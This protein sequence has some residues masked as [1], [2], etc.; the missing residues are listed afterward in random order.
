[1]KIIVATDKYKGTFSSREATHEIAETLRT[2]LAYLEKD[3]EI[4]EKPLA[5]GG[6][7]TAETLGELMG[8]F[9]G[10]LRGMTSRPVVFYVVDDKK[11]VVIDCSSVLSLTM[12][13]E[14]ERGRILEASSFNAGVLIRVIDE[15]IHPERIYLG[16]GG[17]STADGGAGMLQALGARFYTFDRR[18]IDRPVSPRDK[19]VDV[20]FS[21]IKPMNITALCDVDVPLLPR[22]GVAG[23]SLD[24]AWQKGMTDEN[25]PEIERFLRSL[26]FFYPPRENS[27]SEGAGGGIGM[28]L[29]R[30]MGAEMVDGAQFILERS[31]I[32]EEEPDLIITGEGRLDGQSAMGKLPYRLATEG[33]RL[34]IPVVAIA[35]EITSD[36]D[37]APYAAAYSASD[38]LPELDDSKENRLLRLK[39]AAFL[40]TPEIRE[41][42]NRDGAR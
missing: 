9:R 30:V 7:G 6:E 26:D 17:T 13:P 1:M 35:G 33:R 3:C 31:G 5:D 42:L 34:G 14:E 4:V 39:Q 18:L 11:G 22:E 28:A 25:R 40:N 24:F 36:A 37:L 27:R 12:V 19:I 20:D 2:F 41:L 10:E 29:S 32:F 8:S 15:V 21:D 38:Y 23:S 16:V